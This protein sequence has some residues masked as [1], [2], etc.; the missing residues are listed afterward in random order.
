MLIEKDFDHQQLYINQANQYL[1]ENEPLKALAFTMIG[2]QK[3]KGDPA[4]LS[5]MAARFAYPAQLESYYHYYRHGYDATSAPYKIFEC[6][7]KLASTY[8]PFNNKKIAWYPEVLLAAAIAHKINDFDTAGKFYRQAAVSNDQHSSERRRIEK[9]LVQIGQ[10]ENPNAPI[11]Q[12][13]NDQH[14]S[15]RRRIEKILVQIGQ[16]ENPNAPIYQNAPN[17]RCVLL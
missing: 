5:I 10:Q 6:D 3:T 11:Y 12:N 1:Q 9:I 16:Q 8:F 4:A 7:A 17:K 13:S 2:L 15:E 14:P